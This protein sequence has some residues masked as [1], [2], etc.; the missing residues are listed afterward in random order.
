LNFWHRKK[1]QPDKT[2]LEYQEYSLS[3][4]KIFRVEA[5][6]SEKAMELIRTLKKEAQA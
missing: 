5:Q 1:N 2:I 3:S 6:S 4:S